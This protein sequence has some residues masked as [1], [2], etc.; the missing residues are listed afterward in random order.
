QG[1]PVG[2]ELHV[3]DAVAVADPGAERC[4]D[5]PQAEA[6]VVLSP[7]HG[8]AVLRPGQPAAA[9]D[10]P[11]LDLLA[12]LHVPQAADLQVAVLAE[13]ELPVRRELHGVDPLPVAG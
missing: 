13:E 8:L 2:G 7:G 4:P 12:G 11:V 1:L 6:V 5:L 3:E 10:V 9:V